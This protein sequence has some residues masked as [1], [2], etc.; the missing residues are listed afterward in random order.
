MSTHSQSTRPAI[1]SIQSQLV[2]GCAGN[3]AAVPLLQKLGATVYAV[4]TVLLSNTPHYATI[5][6]IDMAPSIVDDL[7]TRL[8]ERVP[9]TQLTAILTGYIRDVETVAV[10]AKFIDRVRTENPDIIVLADPVMGDTDLGLF[11]P[12]EV[13][14]CVKNQLVA[15]AD[16]C[17]PNLFEARFIVG[18][19]DVEPQELQTAM[20]D[21]GAGISVI[22]GLGLEQGA[23]EIQ[24]VAFQRGQRCSTSTPR[25]DIRPTGTGDLLAAAFL[26]HWLVARD[27]SKG[28]QQSVANVY[29]IMQQ[30]ADMKLQEL[31][32]ARL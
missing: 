17:T 8:L 16:I 19:N 2:Y 30:A 24:T 25:L 22:T 15:R 31:E 32:P 26:F 11:I 5:G 27:V 14:H 28:L 18:K 3:N 7:L 9:T 12:E 4:P 21:S 20:L 13:A 1:V 29:S 23:S 6:G 10:V